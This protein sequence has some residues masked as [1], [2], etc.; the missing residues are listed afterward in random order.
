MQAAGYVLVGGN[1]SR[2]GR[3]K[4]FLPGQFRYV[5]DDVAESIQAVTGNVTLIGNPDRF[6]EFHYRCIPDLRAGL[7][8]LSGLEAALAST[9]S[10]LNLVLACDMPAVD[11]DH[12]RLLIGRAQSSLSKCVATEDVTGRIHPLCA[13]YRRECL[14][15]IQWQLDEK[16]LSVMG[17]LDELGTEYVRAQSAIE[18]LNTPEEWAR[19]SSRHPKNIRPVW[20]FQ[21]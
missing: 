3:D 5:L 4:A 11:V 9:V 21:T 6:R 7:G 19:W 20:R 10:D 13:V 2:M 15:L 12:L 18:N 14:P 1:S 17:L 8:P 16:R